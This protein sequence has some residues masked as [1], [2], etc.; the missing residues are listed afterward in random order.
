MA[1]LVGVV[2]SGISIGTLAAQITSSIV[3]LKTYWDEVQDAPEDIQDLIG[4]V[5]DLYLL[6]ADLE[7]DQKR[8]PV[9]SLVLDNTSISS[10]LSHCKQGAD[11]LKELADDLS[12]DFDARSKLRK[13]WASTKV[14]LKKDKLERYRKKLERA[15]R[16]LSLSHQIYIR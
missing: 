2:A 11:R 15:I 10:C 12:T 7:E 1:E 8:N 4:E 9:S 5:E 13:K 16:L 6:L 14:V 3:K